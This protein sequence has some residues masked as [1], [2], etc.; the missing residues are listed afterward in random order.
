MN[1]YDYEV[2]CARDGMVKDFKD[3]LSMEADNSRELRYMKQR[4]YQNRYFLVEGYKR[5]FWQYMPLI[6]DKM[7]LDALDGAN[8]FL[9][10]TTIDK[11]KNTPEKQ[12]T[13]M[14]RSMFNVRF[15][16]TNANIY[17]IMPLYSLGLGCGVISYRVY[18]TCEDIPDEK[19]IL[20]VPILSNLDPKTMVKMDMKDL[21]FRHLMSVFTLALSVID[22][23]SGGTVSTT[24]LIEF[25]TDMIQDEDICKTAK[26]R[27]GLHRVPIKE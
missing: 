10:D 4:Q 26:A 5:V 8:K 20:S 15:G 6:G 1:L 9:T 23:E 19:L 16:F 24:T 25:P 11:R 27:L 2:K 7:W 17:K 21:E 13:T 12:S 14:L 3:M 22:D 18:F